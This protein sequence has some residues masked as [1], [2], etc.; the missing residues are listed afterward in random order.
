[1]FAGRIVMELLVATLAHLNPGREADGAA[2]I[3]LIAET[4]RNAP[5]LVNVQ[6]YQSRSND[7]YY[8]ILTTWEDEKAWQQAR[9]RYNPKGL[10]LGSA[11]E[12]LAQA[13]EQWFMRYL[14]G[15]SRPASKATLAA[16]HLATANH[17]QDE[18]AQRGWI[19]SL[20]RQ[21][22]QPTLAFAFLAR[23]VSENAADSPG[24]ITAIG[25]SAA[26]HRDYDRGPIFLNFLSWANETDRE[27]FYA[28]PDYRAISRFLGSIGVVQALTLEAL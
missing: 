23:G 3:R 18:L 26:D 17:N 24:Q 7:T 19:E 2:R 6:C 22:V 11:T 5:A 14:W 10:L 9:E 1:M 21:V 25:N 13:P 4:I 16:V 20:R 28:D 12:L 27:E 8:F 15:Y